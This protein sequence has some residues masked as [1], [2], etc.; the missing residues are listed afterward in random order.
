MASTIANPTASDTADKVLQNIAQL[1]R[2]LREA[3]LRDDARQRVI[4]DSSFRAELV[5]FWNGNPVEDDTVT[6]EQAAAI[7]GTNFHGVD[8]LQRHLGVKL[9][10]KSKKLFL[11]V[12]FSAAMLQ[13]C[14]Q[15]HVLVACGALSLMDVWQP[16]A[17]CSTPRRSRGTVSRASV[18]LTPSSRLVGNWSARIWCLVP[19]PRLG[20]SSKHC[21]RVTIWC[22]E[23]RCWLRSSSSTTWRPRSGCSRG[24]TSALR[25]W[26][27]LANTCTSATLAGTVSSST[28]AGS[29]TVSAASA[30]LR[31]GSS[32]RKYLP[33]GNSMGF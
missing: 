20:M 26:A 10:T 12:P 9:S 7:M 32:A 24:S 18:G 8:A 30:S 25:T 2:L 31:P 6:P 27:P 11:N 4:D 22:P 23:L 28:T 13:A 29:S 14:A 1:H 15:T 5:R 3:G 21:S 17:A 33:H 19:P 16:K